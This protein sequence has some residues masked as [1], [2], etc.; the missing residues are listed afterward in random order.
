MEVRKAKMI[1]NTSGAGSSTF[2]AT[3]PSTWVRKMGLDEKKRNLKLYFDGERIIIKNNE[4][5]IRM[6]EKLLG[7]AKVEIEKEMNRLGYIDDSDNTDRFLDNLARELA[8]EE[9]LKGNEDI[10]FYYE[11]EFEIEEL[12]EELLKEIKDKIMSKY[13]SF[14]TCENGHYE[15]CYYEIDKEFND[16]DEFNNHFGIGE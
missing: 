1:V 8:K 2:R 16:W 15:A 3:L 12:Q 14:S 13:N 7:L 5:E 6:L 10:D 9:I 11:K 4:E